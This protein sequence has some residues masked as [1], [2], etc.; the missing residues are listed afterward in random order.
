MP[1]SGSIVASM[2]PP[3]MERGRQGCRVRRRCWRCWR[4]WG[5]QRSR[6]SLRRRGPTGPMSCAEL[7]WG[8]A[9]SPPVPGPLEHPGSTMGSRVSELRAVVEIGAMG[10]VGVGVG[11]GVA[12]FM[13]S[14]LH[15]GRGGAN[16]SVGTVENSLVG[17][18]CGGGDAAR[19]S[20]MA[21]TPR[22]SLGAAPNRH[23]AP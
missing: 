15:D 7:G 17:A 19:A 9:G 18:C 23:R 12:V 14:S 20:K 21:G 10:G 13:P 4:F 5:C 1:T 3:A 6:G 2:T 16:R 11:V 22:V 8:G